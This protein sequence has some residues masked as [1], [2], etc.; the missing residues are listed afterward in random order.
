MYLRAEKLKSGSLAVA[1]FVAVTALVVEVRTTKSGGR[2]MPAASSRSMITGMILTVI[3]MMKW[4]APQ[5]RPKRGCEG[6][7]EPG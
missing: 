7:G 6:W 5:K 4:Y 1:V 3:V 2:S